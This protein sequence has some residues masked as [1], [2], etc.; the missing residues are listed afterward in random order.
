MKRK[1][2][3]I[4][5]VVLMLVSVLSSCSVLENL[6][7]AIWTSDLVGLTF[8]LKDDGT[9]LVEIGEAKYFSSITI[10]STYNGVPVT[11]VG[12]FNNTGA[13]NNTLKEVTISEGITSIADRA[14]YNC[15][16]LTNVTI[17]KSVTTIG[18]DAFYG[19]NAPLYTQH[20][21]GTYVGDRKN[22][23]A[24]LIKVR[25]ENLGDYTIPE[26]TT[27]IA[28]GAFKGCTSLNSVIIPNSVTA[29]SK[30]M[31]YGCLN[32]KSIT[33]P[34]SVTTIGESAFSGC[35]Y[36]M[37][38]VIPDSVVTIG[39]FA[40]SDCR[41]LISV[42]IGQQVTAIGKSAFKGCSSLTS[43]TFARSDNWWYKWTTGINETAVSALELSNP[44]T[45]ARYLTSGYYWYRTEQ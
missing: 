20:E 18:E 21:G 15:A 44:T 8:S 36:L 41:K 16:N 19:C 32:L 23:Y 22:P 33:I 9:Y 25:N 30:D 5:L 35:S 43:A 45:A 40:F 4:V 12:Q 38:I 31:F 42:T 27:I 29:I 10:P 28:N 37:S 1:I 7:S 26:Q 13:I 34:N 39:D 6:Q 3:C 11:E 14:F 2:L 24:A 17:P